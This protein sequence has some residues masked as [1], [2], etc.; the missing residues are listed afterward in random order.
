[1]QAT[2]AQA[3]TVQ[4]DDRTV[5]KPVIHHVNLKTTRLD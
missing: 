4:L 3:A 5:F 1:M 2:S